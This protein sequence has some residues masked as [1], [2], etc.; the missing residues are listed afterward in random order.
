MPHKGERQTEPVNE[1][2]GEVQKKNV[3]PGHHLI[4]V[5]PT[6]NPLIPM[7]FFIK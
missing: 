2:V 7:F 1:E 6:C 4:N 3:V 5:K